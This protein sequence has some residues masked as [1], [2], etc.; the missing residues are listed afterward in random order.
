LNLL[1]QATGVERD[2]LPSEAADLIAECGRLPLAVALCGGLIRHGFAWT[3][4]LEQL[5]TSRIDR[6]T[7]PHAVRVEHENIWNAIDVSV[8]SLSAHEQPRFLALAVFPPDEATPITTLQTLWSHT[9]GFD[10]WDTEAL[11][12]KLS[13][14]SLLELT[15]SRNGK[16]ISL[17][18]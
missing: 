15:T 11:V 1:A 13:Q 7:D 14:R 3:K 4:V 2:Q 9:A 8:R 16:A 12:I 6:I 5:R 10:D 17:H 18:A